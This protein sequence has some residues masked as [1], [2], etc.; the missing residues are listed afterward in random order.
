MK[1][2]A[3]ATEPVSSQ[4]A[5]YH[6]I[7]PTSLAGFVVSAC[8]SCHLTWLLKVVWMSSAKGPATP[9][10]LRFGSIREGLHVDGYLR[11]RFVARGQ[12]PGHLRIR[13]SPPTDS[14]CR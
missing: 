9:K 10:L 4:R 3:S 2:S 5:P 8:A 1:Q 14:P 13:V 12:I 7:R 11:R 6:W